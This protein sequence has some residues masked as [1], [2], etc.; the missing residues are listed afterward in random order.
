[1]R[2]RAASGAIA[3]D[4]VSASVGICAMKPVRAMSVVV[5]IAVHNVACVFRGVKQ[6]RQPEPGSARPCAWVESL[7]FMAWFTAISDEVLMPTC[8]M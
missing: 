7:C 4:V 5:C 1:M 6:V 8:H 2:T 3:R